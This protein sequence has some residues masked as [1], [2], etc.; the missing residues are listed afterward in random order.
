MDPDKCDTGLTSPSLKHGCSM[1]DDE[2]GWN[3]VENNK[4][5]SSSKKM[6]NKM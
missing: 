1:L 5:N 2:G 3:K 4:R 6:K